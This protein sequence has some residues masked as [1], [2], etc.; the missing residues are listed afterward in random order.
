MPI[1]ENCGLSFLQKIIH[2][3]QQR[4]YVADEWIIA[5][6]Y[7]ANGMYIQNTGHT[8]IVCPEMKAI[9]RVHGF[10]GYFGHE[11]L[12]RAIHL[13][14]TDENQ[15]DKYFAR[16]VTESELWFLDPLHFRMIVETFPESLTSMR[17][18]LVERQEELSQANFVEMSVPTNYM[19]DFQ[20]TYVNPS[21]QFMALWRCAVLIGNTWNAILIPFRVAF[22]AHWTFSWRIT[23]IDYVIDI[24][25]FIDIIIRSRYLA[26]VKDDQ[27]T[28]T[29]LEIMRNYTRN[30]HVCVHIISAI[31]F[32][33]CFF[34]TN[35]S[36]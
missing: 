27:L 1:V 2:I 36:L 33:I 4:F 5:E 22:A 11:T 19:H 25:F 7:P 8:E 29:A 13:S 23:T 21:S 24:I 32:E 28:T 17:L 35:V 34:F 31:P 30:D 10:G 15:E 16:T 14:V 3:L 18:S 26:F 9:K 20:D 12:M 6:R